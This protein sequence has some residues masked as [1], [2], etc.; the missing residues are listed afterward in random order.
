MK[1][2]CLVSP[3]FTGLTF[4]PISFDS[5]AGSPIIAFKGVQG[6]LTVFLIPVDNSAPHSSGLSSYS[7]W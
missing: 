3:S 5:P 4:T 1:G 7:L 6:R 2:R